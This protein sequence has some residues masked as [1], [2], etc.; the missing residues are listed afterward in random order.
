MKRRTAWILVAGVAAVSVGAAAVGA[1]A[2]VLRQS[3]G[4]PAMGGNSCVTLDVEGDIPEAPPPQEFGALLERRPPS[5]KTLLEGLDRAGKDPKVSSV[6]LRVGLLE[7]AGW[8]KVQELRDAVQRFRKSGK[9]AYAHIEFCGNKEYY[10]ATAADKIYATPTAIVNVSGLAVEVMFFRGTLD[11]L[12]IQAQFEGV[13][14]YKNARSEE[15][16]SE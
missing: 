1:V 6:L 3:G 10:L 16:T 12:G 7:G 5:L 15:H 2:Y 13:G 9:P 11:K 8:G 4:A 14:K